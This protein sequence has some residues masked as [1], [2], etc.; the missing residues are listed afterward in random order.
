MKLV[1]FSTR[2][3][4]TVAMLMVAIIVFGGVGFSRL[5][6]N[7]LPDITYPT[8]TVR[9]EYPG[10]APLEIERLLSE[11]VEGL[12]GV[13]SN[14]VRVNSISRPGVSDVIV[15]FAWGTNMDFASLDLREKLSTA[16]HCQ[17]RNDPFALAHIQ[18]IIVTDLLHTT[19]EKLAGALIPVESIKGRVLFLHHLFDRWTIRFSLFL[20]AL[21]LQISEFYHLSPKGL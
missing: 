9:T 14:V 5:A 17:G 19:L 20:L 1:E 6:V 3:R 4:V 21:F 18:V 8:I 16:L 7:L 15:E 12:V 10:V 13:V 11:P 2:R